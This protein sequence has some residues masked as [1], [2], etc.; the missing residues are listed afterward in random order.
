MSAPGLSAL[1]SQQRIGGIWSGAAGLA[2]RA[3]RNLLRLAADLPYVA[4]LY[5]AYWH[6]V[7]MDKEVP[8]LERLMIN[9]LL[10][11]KSKA[12]LRRA[13]LAYRRVREDSL[14][15]WAELAHIVRLVDEIREVVDGDN[16]TEDESR[17][18]AATEAKRLSRHEDHV[19]VL[20]S[21]YA[22]FDRSTSRCSGPLFKRV[23][24]LSAKVWGGSTAA[25]IDFVFYGAWYEAEMAQLSRGALAEL[26]PAGTISF[27]MPL[28]QKMDANGD[29][30][31]D[32]DE[33]VDAESG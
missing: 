25:L 13:G 10:S 33:F 21:L 23:K 12:E 29:G 31:I 22:D 14:A 3:G 26:V 32:E 16:P 24:C 20:R 6:M 19:R 8:I 5:K 11:A 27:A 28:L 1:M 2:G 30:V 15:I 17:A 9:P 18:R 7:V 4:L